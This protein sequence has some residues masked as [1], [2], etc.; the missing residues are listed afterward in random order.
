MHPLE[1]CNRSR[2]ALEADS[3]LAIQNIANLIKVT[4][5]HNWSLS[6]KR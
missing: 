4:K 6:C 1:P 3:R 2:V 5:S